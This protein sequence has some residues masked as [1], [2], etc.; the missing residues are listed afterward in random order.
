MDEL[1]NDNDM[2]EKAT[3]IIE[4]LE[5]FKTQQ[6]SESVISTVLKT[7]ALAEELVENVNNN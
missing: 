6:I 2:I 3:K 1:K 5:S 4:L 7:Q